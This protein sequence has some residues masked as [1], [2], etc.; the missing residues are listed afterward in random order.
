MA[1]AQTKAMLG[2]GTEAAAPTA[3]GWGDHF[4]CRLIRFTFTMARHVQMRR[5]SPRSL[6][7]CPWAPGEDQT[8]QVAVW[9]LLQS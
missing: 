6:F 8:P 9:G 5:A 4:A 2:G 1:L 3:Q 7:S